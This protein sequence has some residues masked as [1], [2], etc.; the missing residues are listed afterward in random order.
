MIPLPPGVILLYQPYDIIVCR[1]RSKTN[2][3]LR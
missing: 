2:N 3:R 1:C